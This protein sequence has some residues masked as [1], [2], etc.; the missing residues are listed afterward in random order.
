MGPPV[1]FAVQTWDRVQL[2]ADVHNRR[3]DFVG[4]LRFGALFGHRTSRPG[5][6]GAGPAFG[7]RTTR[8]DTVSGSVGLA[9]LLA[10]DSGYQARAELEYGRTTD[11]H[12]SFVAATLE[13]GMGI[14]FRGRGHYAHR[15]DGGL[16]LTY[17]RYVH[18][19]E[20]RILLGFSVQTFVALIAPLFIRP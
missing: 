15:I 4:G 16:A 6:F 13:L 11:G 10:L 19:D 5:F 7:L 20:R 1:G 18:S 9:G 12:G 2:G 14:A 3:W 8:F 17:V